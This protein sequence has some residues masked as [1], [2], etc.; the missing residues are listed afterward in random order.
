MK[1][2]S[3]IIILFL[4]PYML[5]AQELSLDSCRSLTLQ[6][7]KQLLHAKLE[8]KAA[9]QVKK[10]AFTNY[11]PKIS[12]Q[13]FAMRASDYM[14]KE[15][16][17]EANLPVYDGNPLNLLQPTQ[18]AYF[19]GMQIETFD[20]TNI[21]ALTAIQPIF[22]GGRIING[23]KLAK[24]GMEVSEE[25]LEIKKEELILKTENYYWQIVM[26]QEKQ[27]TLNAYLQMLQSL[28]KDVSVA[29]QSGLVQK[30]DLLKVQLKLNDVE[31]KKYRLENGIEIL[32][33]AFCQHMGIEYSGNFQLSDSLTLIETPE[34]V[35][36]NHQQALYNRKEYDMLQKSLKA[37][38]LKKRMILGENLP[39]ISLGVQGLYLD[40]FDKQ[41][42]YGIAF[43]T[44]SIPISGWWGAAHKLS[45]HKIKE[46]IAQTELQ[47]KSE[48]MLLQMEKAYK[49]LNESYRQIK[50]AEISVKQAKEHLKI[51]SDNYKAGVVNT[52][53]MLEA[54]A[55]LLEEENKLS[56]A[57][58]NYKM[59]VLNYKRVVA[60][61]LQ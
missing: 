55:A 24:I 30:S 23:N 22:T 21:A 52:S 44:V 58:S 35:Y 11:F 1:K 57:K 27:Q 56:E 16:I 3:I 45:E 9:E 10:E 7:N 41:N 26:L 28:Y 54:Q 5:F 46:E 59:K 53:D 61:D 47:E 42:S 39:Q 14:I 36:V 40:A 31:V 32:K 29:Y 6:N 4:M 49:D 25:Q 19:P 43:A 38:K 13:G 20:Y 17:P 18:F 34:T 60:V 51:V 2:I 33:M 15:E 8:V 50:I 12:A 37:E 48:L